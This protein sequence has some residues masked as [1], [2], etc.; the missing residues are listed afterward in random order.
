MAD[1]RSVHA[2]GSGSMG[3]R[4]SWCGCMQTIITADV[5][6]FDTQQ[7]FDRVVSIEMFEHMKNYQVGYG[8][9]FCCLVVR[10]GCHLC[11]GAALHA[12]F[13]MLSGAMIL[14][15]RYCG[16]LRVG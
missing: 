16:T 5:V 10:D 9:C 13:G 11:R 6:E 3:E 14:H 7:K 15:R 4:Q 8:H 2:T 12:P 1:Q